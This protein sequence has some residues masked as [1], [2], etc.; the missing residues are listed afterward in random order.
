ML[1]K[2]IE[3]FVNLSKDI[4]FYQKILQKTE[5]EIIKFFL[6]TPKY[7]ITHD[8]DPPFDSS[9]VTMIAEDS[10][11][12]KD[13]L[14][15]NLAELMEEVYT[16][17]STPTFMSGCGLVHLTLLNKLD[18]I[19]RDIY[20][21]LEEVVKLKE[22]LEDDENDELIET[23]CDM[24]ID[25]SPFVLEITK[26]FEKIHLI[27]IYKRNIENA[28][29]ELQIEKEEREKRAQ[30]QEE[31]SLYYKNIF[32]SFQK[33]YRIILQKRVTA[34]DMD[35]LENILKEDEFYTKEFFKFS[36]DLSLSGINDYSFSQGAEK[37]I[38][39]LYSL[40]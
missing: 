16:G 31:K 27:E 13:I 21:D 1:E 23:I 15:R 11:Q 22:G 5:I 10:Y 18:D 6:T 38:K 24:F 3:G 34:K 17:D 7:Q 4:N 14:F 40:I 29:K 12:L 28:E 39:K 37:R 19:V 32:E 26:Y 8:Y 25:D 2:R 36:T 30:E 9:G 20:W 33:K 35:R